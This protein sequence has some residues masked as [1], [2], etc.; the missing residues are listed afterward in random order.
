MR[1]HA[2]RRD[3]GDDGVLAGECRFEGV[4]GGVVRCEGRGV[5]GQ[6]AGRG[7]GG[8]V[9]AGDGGDG[10]AGVLELGDD[11]GAEVACALVV[12]RWVLVRGCI[13]IE[14][15]RGGR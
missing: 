8:G 5:G 13:M 4:E 9:G 3:G 7:G 15:R 12:G 2:L 6:G 14:K 10:E 11:G 1:G